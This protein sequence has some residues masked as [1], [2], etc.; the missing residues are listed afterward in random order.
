MSD[1]LL[2]TAAAYATLAGV[3]G[4]ALAGLAIYLVVSKKRWLPLQRL[5]PGTWAGYEVILAGCVV[6]GLPLLMVAM[7]FSIGFFN[8]LLGVPPEM[9]PPGPAA[10][11]YLLRCD[12]VASPLTFAATL[13][14]LFGVLYARSQTRPRHYGLS[15]ARWPANLGLGVA[16]FLVV[17]PVVLSLHALITLGQPEEHPFV[18]LSRRMQGWEWIFFAF[19]AIVRAPVLEEIF[20]RGILLGWLRRAS[21]GGHLAVG[22]ITI[23]V[24]MLQTLGMPSAWDYVGPGVFA[25]LCAAGYAFLMYRMAREFR[26]N[27]TEI[28]QWQLEPVNF[29]QEGTGIASEEGL[30]EM[31]RQQ[32][33]A[34][35]RRRQDWA[36][37]NAWLAVFGSAVMFAVCHSGVWPAPDP[38]LLLAVVLGGLALRTQSL[39]GPITLHAL[40]NLVSFIVLYGSTL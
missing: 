12:M 11:S 25:V 38:L 2:W 20:F 31:R 7:L 15:W 9:D 37:Q 19:Q 22:S 26:L 16:A 30:R 35:E 14:I 21:L 6:N 24:A 32:R 28:Q 23:F 27:E 4:V 33:E 5:R 29:T 39:V 3:A 17:T 18:E 36:Q 34:D 13:G 1:E 40:F 10:R 8:P